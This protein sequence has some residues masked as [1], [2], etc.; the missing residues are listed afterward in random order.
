MTLFQL[1]EVL[2]ISRIT[3]ICRPTTGPFVNGIT[4]AGLQILVNLYSR[5]S[6][7]YYTLIILSRELGPIAYPRSCPSLLDRGGH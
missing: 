4:S 5:Q 1:V 6:T 2:H 3:R 7:E